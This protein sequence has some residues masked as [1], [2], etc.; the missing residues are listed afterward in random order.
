VSDTP[1]TEPL[2]P[3]VAEPTDPAGFEPAPPA[4]AEWYEAAL[5]RGGPD[6][7]DGPDGSDPYGD[8]GFGPI[9]EPD[10]PVVYLPPE[11]GLLRRAA[12]V[13]GIVVVI[14][15]LMLAGFGW[16]VQRQLN[17]P[18]APGRAVEV[19][20]PF[21]SSDSQIANL[22]AARGVVTNSTVFQAYLRLRGAGPF[23]AGLYD[24]LYAPEDM[25]AVVDRLDQGPLPPLTTRLVIPEGLWLSE[26]RA[27]ILKAFPQ[28]KPADL[29][30]ALHT[31]R[32]KYE[33]PGSNNLEGL[34]FPATYEVLLGDRTNAT[35]LVQQMVTTFDEHADRLGLSQAAQQLGV[36][37]YQVLTV[38]SMVEEEA[39]L[40][41]DRPKVA[42]VIYNRLHQGMSLG[43]DATVEYALQKRTANL[44]QS[45]LETDSPYNTRV[46]TG[47]PPTP[48]GSPGDASLQAAMHPASGDW[49]YFVVV[50]RNGGEYFTSSYSDFQRASEK[51]K[52]EGIFGG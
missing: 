30:R 35:K 44:T 34:L 20:I 41:G 31:V 27:R 18:N 51:A 52:S 47:L 38:A 6:G 36:S 48:I 11:R 46:H 21:N 37:P 2:E 49:I 26:I 33:A 9:D 23:R 8:D 5:S 22:L 42:R 4:E 29:D 10:E 40:P 19:N 7:P 24:Q 25:S 12:P 13:A 32:S 3:P 15:L 14:L 16:W 45:E 17:P 28:M 39:K 1:S 50:D 43:I